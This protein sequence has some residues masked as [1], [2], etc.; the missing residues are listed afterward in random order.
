MTGPKSDRIILAAIS[1]MTLM[2]LASC[3]SMDGSGVSSATRTD[4]LNQNVV[5]LNAPQPAAEGEAAY[6]FILGYEAEITGD[7]DSALIHYRRA[8][9][10]DPESQSI[11]LQLSGVLLKANRHIEAE[12]TVRKL[13]AK[14]PD[15]PKILD[16]LAQIYRNTGNHEKAIEIYHKITSQPGAKNEAFVHLAVLLATDGQYS[17]AEKAIRSM[18]VEDAELLASSLFY[19]G[20]IAMEVKDYDEAK[21]LFLQAEKVKPD[22]DGLLVNLGTVSERLEDNKAAE[23]YYL[24]AVQ[25]DPY[26]PATQ[27]T[28]AKFY[29]RTEQEEKALKALEKLGGM[30]PDNAELHRRIGFIHL[31][32]NRYDKAIEELKAALDIEPSNTETR[33]FLGVA[34]E[35]AEMYDE[36]ISELRKV[37]ALEPANIKPYISLGFVYNQL[38]MYQEAIDSFTEALN[39]DDKNVDIYAYIGRTYKSMGDM[40]RSMEVLRDAAARFP[41]SDEVQFSLA[42]TYDDLDQF[43]EMVVALRRA[44]EINPENADALNYLGYSFAERGINLKEAHDLI[45]KALD[46]KPGN[47]YITDSLGWVY[48]KLGRNK[49]ALDLIKKAS[50]LVKDDPVILD[51]LGDIHHALGNNKEAASAWERCLKAEDARDDKEEG[52]AERVRQKLD[53]IKANGKKRN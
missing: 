14:R 41:E 35:S 6:E 25:A 12:E 50:E 7:A 4:W 32:G 42:V 1:A 15:D 23:S 53:S 19:I 30:V 46:L 33:Y 3:A 31:S 28:L 10:L 51:H 27:E 43:D 26:E 29:L 44:I 37:S 18:P 39:I 52:L 48:F 40:Q 5:I 34:Y 21:K 45:K 47:G 38:G 8:L 16:M 13:Y 20:V 22:L 49:E 9:E 36:A 24:R 17:E 11:M 2:L